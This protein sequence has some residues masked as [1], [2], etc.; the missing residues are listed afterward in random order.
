M[1]IYILF[2]AIFMINVAQCEPENFAIE[3]WVNLGPSYTTVVDA[4]TKWTVEGLKS[5]YDSFTQFNSAAWDEQVLSSKSTSYEV[6]ITIEP[7]GNVDRYG[8]AIIFV[9]Q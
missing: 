2:T 9:P 4:G 6:E 5:S 3:T 7:D 8:Q 1:A